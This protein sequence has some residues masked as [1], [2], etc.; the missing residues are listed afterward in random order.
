MNKK[1]MALAL[2]L[3]LT[4]GTAGASFAAAACKGAVTKVE[5]THVTVKCAD[6]TE[7]TVEGAAKVGDKVTVKDGKLVAAKAK[8]AIEGC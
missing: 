1:I 6:G 8:K 3:A 2:A 5:G 7:V 4:F